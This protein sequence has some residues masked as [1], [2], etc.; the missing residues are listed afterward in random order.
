MDMT[1]PPNAEKNAARGTAILSPRVTLR[2][3]SIVCAASG[4]S[5]EAARSQKTKNHYGN[6]SNMYIHMSGL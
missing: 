4:Q 3:A 5:T 2:A 1:F 6:M